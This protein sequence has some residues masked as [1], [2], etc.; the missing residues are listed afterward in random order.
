MK[1]Q[2]VVLATVLVTVMLMLCVP[3]ALAGTSVGGGGSTVGNSS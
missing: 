3:Y 1:K 2:T